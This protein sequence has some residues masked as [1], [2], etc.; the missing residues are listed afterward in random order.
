MKSVYCRKS[1]N[2]I[3]VV[4][5]EDQPRTILDPNLLKIRN[6]SHAPV[7]SFATLLML[8]YLVTEDKENLPSQSL[9]A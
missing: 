4:R 9:V 1:K 6:N 8:I 7:A 5:I 3:Y 2:L